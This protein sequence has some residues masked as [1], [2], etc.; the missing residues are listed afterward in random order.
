MVIR[1]S[2]NYGLP[3]EEIDLVALYD[4]TAG[5][6]TT[7]HPLQSLV[8]SDNVEEAIHGSAQAQETIVATDGRGAQISPESV[9]RQAT[10]ASEIGHLGEVAFS[11]WLEA[12]GYGD[13]RV[14]WVSQVHARAAYDF[15]V[16]APP[17]TDEDGPIHIDVKATKGGHENSFH[18]SRAEV[19]WAAVNLS[20]RIAR[21]SG[22]ANGVAEIHI[23]G[24]VSEL[25]QRLAES[26]SMLP[27]GAAVDSFELSPALLREV[28]TDRVRWIDDE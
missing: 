4:V 26:T 12:A 18:M 3:I 16:E 20:Y 28:H 1:R 23:L 10:A 24:G 21:I 7:S 8:T 17:W 27:E 25:C 9:W 14:E 6:Y 19:R 22:L 15:I 11:R 2:C 5:A 13:E